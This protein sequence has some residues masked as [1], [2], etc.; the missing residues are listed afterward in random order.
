MAIDWSTV[1]QWAGIAGT[2]LVMIA[3]LPQILHLVMMKCSG[4]LSLKAYVMWG[5]ASALLLIHAFGIKAQIFIVLTASQ[6]AA[7]LLITYLG[8]IYRGRR[9]PMHGGDGAAPA[10]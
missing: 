7:T 8:W 10:S 5:L 4:A 6:L 2:A 3:Y 1:Q 9:C